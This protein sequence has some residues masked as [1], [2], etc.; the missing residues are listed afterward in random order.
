MNNEIIIQIRGLSKT[1]NES[2]VLSDF[3]MEVFEGDFCGLIGPDN[4][5]KTMLLRILATLV[6]PDKGKIEVFG[7]S[8]VTYRQQILKDMGMMIGT[9]VFYEHL[10][11]FDNLAMYAV[12]SG[13]GKDNEEINRVLRITGLLEMA[14]TKVKYFA[15]GDKKK[16]GIALAIYNYPSI[17]MLDDP[18]SGLDI[19]SIVKMKE[20]FKSLNSERGTTFIIASNQLSELEGLISRMIL[21]EAG[22]LIAE[23]SIDDLMGRS[24]IG[25]ILDTSNNEVAVKLLNEDQLPV[26]DA[27]IR[28]GLIRLSCDSELIP[29]INKLL[30]VSDIQV[31][32]LRPENAITSYYLTFTK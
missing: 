16:L 32:M 9:P 15:S 1:V 31:K 4:A 2:P 23:G 6:Q 8:L 24:K 25:L 29:Y 26:S 19:K 20:L 30:V 14:D 13:F 5:G 11:A 17:V 18:F 27:A 3:S 28:G 12:Y 7:K 22:Q 10:T 21:M